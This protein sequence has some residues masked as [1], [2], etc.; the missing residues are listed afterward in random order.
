M[1]DYASFVAIHHLYFDI[2]KLKLQSRASFQNIV[3][4]P[5]ALVFAAF[6]PKYWYLQHLAL[7]EPQVLQIPALGA[8]GA[9]GEH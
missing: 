3:C 4:V 6:G 8:H 9:V 7:Y 1:L 2:S 5:Q